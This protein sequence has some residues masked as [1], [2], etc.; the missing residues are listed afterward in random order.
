MSLVLKWNEIIK[1]LSKNEPVTIKSLQSNVL[2]NDWTNSVA[3]SPVLSNLLSRMKTITIHKMQV[4][5]H[6]KLTESDCGSI[7]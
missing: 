3:C 1:A 7:Y 4:K 5:K 2:L 6:F